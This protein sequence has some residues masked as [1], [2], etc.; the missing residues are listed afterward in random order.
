MPKYGTM[1]DKALSLYSLM[2]HNHVKNVKTLGS[3]R[4]E[5]I[6]PVFFLLLYSLILIFYCY[7]YYIF[8]LLLSNYAPKNLNS[9]TLQ[10]LKILN[11]AIK[12]F[13]NINLL[14]KQESNDGTSIE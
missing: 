8:L 12:I 6:M 4:L 1:G 2:F 10:L 3:A 14:F 11:N 7:Y 13:A 9:Q 5:I